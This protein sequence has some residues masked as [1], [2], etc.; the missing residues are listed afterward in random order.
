[1]TNTTGMTP[2]MCASYCDSY[3]WFGIEYSSECYCGA[4]PRVGSVLQSDNSTCNML[5]SGD[6]TAYC[7]GGNRLNMYFSDNSTKASTD[8]MNVDTTGA[9]SFYS[10]YKDNVRALSV[11]AT[12]DS[13]SVDQCRKIAA[14]GGYLWFGTEYE[15]ECWTGD[16]LAAGT[17]NA[18]ASE[19]NMACKGMPSQ[20]CGGPSRL[21]LYKRNV[22][23][24]SI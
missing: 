22:N 15:R 17:G 1:M 14:A 6:S 20:L 8:P 23:Q 18:T 5:C 11:L 19:C 7:G 21:S 2:A 13:M 10:C 3:A 12:S 24:T 9:Y 4:Y 16:S